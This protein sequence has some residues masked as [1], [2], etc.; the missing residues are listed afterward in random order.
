MAEAKVHGANPH[1]TGAGDAVCGAPITFFDDVCW[2]FTDPV[3]RL[4]FYRQVD[5][6]AAF[7]PHA[8][9]RFLPLAGIL[10][11][12]AR[13]FSYSSGHDALDLHL[14]WTEERDPAAAD[15]VRSRC[16]PRRRRFSAEE[17]NPAADEGPS[18]LRLTPPPP[19]LP[20][21]DG[22]EEPGRRRRPSPLYFTPPPLLEEGEGP[23]W[24][25][26]GERREGWGR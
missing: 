21:L 22:G 6:A 8:L 18:P 5:P 19:P 16:V 7:P 2:L 13:C 26:G 20:L 25:R 23:L 14:H 3:E 9:T 1:G 11:P 24:R 10:S 12:A 15:A 4:F 17:R